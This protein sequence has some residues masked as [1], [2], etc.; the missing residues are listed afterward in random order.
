MT[1]RVFEEATGSMDEETLV[2]GASPA[3]RAPYPIKAWTEGTY[4]FTLS[5]KSDAF[6]YQAHTARSKIS[7]RT[8]IRYFSIREAVECRTLC[9]MAWI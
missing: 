5:K 9:R 7:I 8:L 2:E 4:R 3:Q 6:G 1:R